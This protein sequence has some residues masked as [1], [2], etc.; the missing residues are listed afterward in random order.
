MLIDAIAESWKRLG[1]GEVVD[2]HGVLRPL[3]LARLVEPM[4]RRPIRIRVLAELG[5]DPP[6]HNTFLNCLA[7]ARDR[8][9]R[10]QIAGECFD[11]SVATTGISLLLYDVTTLYFR[12]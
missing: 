11:H 6:H 1:F 2:D 9:Y 4:R 10:A 8:D 7:R 3:V 5:I 12:G